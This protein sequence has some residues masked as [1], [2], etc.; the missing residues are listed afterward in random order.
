MVSKKYSTIQF[1]A[2]DLVKVKKAQKWLE[3]ELG[4]KLSLSQTVLY[5]VDKIN[6]FEAIK[7]LLAKYEGIIESNR[8]I[9]TYSVPT[10]MSPS[11]FN[12]NSQSINPGLGVN[13]NNLRLGDD[14]EFILQ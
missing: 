14:G 8:S 2:E 10:L 3:L 1:T 12:T 13:S 9:S 7:K 5:G 4:T 11:T 6:K